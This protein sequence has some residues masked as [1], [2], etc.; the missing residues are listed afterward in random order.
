[1]TID[2]GKPSPSRIL[3][4]PSW[5]ESSPP[6]STASALVGGYSTTRPNPPQTSHRPIRVYVDETGIHGAKYSAFGSLWMTHDRR[7][8]FQAIYDA[9]R[10]AS[11]YIG[12]LK[13]TKVSRFSADFARGMIEEF[14]KRPWLMFHAL[15]IPRDYVNLGLHENDRD[16]AY[17]KHLALFL[18]KKIAWIADGKSKEFHVIVDPLPSRYQKADEAAHIIINH[19]LKRDAGRHAQIASLTTRDSRETPG[20]Q[21]AD[22]L[23]GAA[24]AS[25]QGEITSEPKKRISKLVAEHLGWPDTKA[26]TYPRESKFNLWHFWDPT[27]GAA[28]E[29]RTRRVRLTYPM[30]PFVPSKYRK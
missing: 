22:L 10:K 4:V 14:F 7:G 16:L 1:M 17:R 26:D 23:L 8:D 29:V 28:R 9:Q 15:I 20:I 19:T 2:S 30:T 3:T 18:A 21:L 12:E 24:L 6:E 25:W 13:W 5:L 11:G 27:A